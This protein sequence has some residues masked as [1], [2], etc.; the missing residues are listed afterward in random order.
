M[1]T[2][3]TFD[4]FEVH[5]PAEIIKRLAKLEARIA[6]IEEQKPPSDDL[7]STAEV[8]ELLGIHSNTWYNWLR[9]YPKPPTALGSPT[10]PRYRKSSVIRFATRIGKF[11]IS[12]SEQSQDKKK[13]QEVNYTQRVKV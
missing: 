7:I 10:S 8:I 12:K 1:P 3:I 11:T 9:R 13:S 5:L 4:S 6:K 2:G